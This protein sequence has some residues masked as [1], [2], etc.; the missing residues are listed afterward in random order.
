MPNASAGSAAAKA[1]KKQTPQ[2][3]QAPA[4]LS[5][6]ELAVVLN[7]LG[8]RPDALAASGCTAPEIGDVVG[9]TRQHLETAVQDLRSADVAWGNAKGDVDRLERLVRGGKAESVQPLRAARAAFQAADAQRSAVLQRITDA[10]LAGL[11]PSKASVLATIHANAAL[12]DM[13]AQYLAC[14]LSEPD[15]VRLRS[16]LANDRIAARQHEDP[17]PGLHQFLGQVN[18]NPEVSAASA[19]LAVTADLQTAWNSAVFR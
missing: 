12:W 14:S 13:P 5:N 3:A 8:I 2:A 9:R 7:R 6:N 15:R 18:A 4:P 1:K 17:D 16:A 10:A 19:H 11:D